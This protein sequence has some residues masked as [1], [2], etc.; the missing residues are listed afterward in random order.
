MELGVELEDQELKWGYGDNFTRPNDQD[1]DFN[2]NKICK[3]TIT[4]RYVLKSHFTMPI[5]LEGLW[6]RKPILDEALAIPTEP[7]TRSKTK[8]YQ[9]A[10]MAFV[11]RLSP[12]KW[13]KTHERVD[14]EVLDQVFGQNA[15]GS[16]Q[17]KT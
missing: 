7:M 13:L 10:L 3:G 4:R 17:G 11:Q 1:K 16:L 9:E 15:W 8:K 12:R 14:E 5:Y 2:Q 6:R